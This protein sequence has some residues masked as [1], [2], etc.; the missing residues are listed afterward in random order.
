MFR[1]EELNDE[2]GKWLRRINQSVCQ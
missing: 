2:T 1:F